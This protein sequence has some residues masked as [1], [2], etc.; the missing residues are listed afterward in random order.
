MKII[1]YAC[2]LS[3]YDLA[4]I[5]LYE[6]QYGAHVLS[7]AC[8][9]ERFTFKSCFAL[10]LFIMLTTVRELYIFKCIGACTY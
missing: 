8:A 6:R 2:I 3:G 1:Q 5:V 4:I 10:S 9:F 7:L